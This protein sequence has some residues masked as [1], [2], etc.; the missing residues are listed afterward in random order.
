MRFQFTLLSL[1]ASIAGLAFAAPAPIV[2]APALNRRGST[3]KTVTTATN[4]NLSGASGAVILP[5]PI[6]SNSSTLNPPPTGVNSTTNSTI[7]LLVPGGS[8]ST[9]FTGRPHFSPASGGIVIPHHNSTGN[10]TIGK[11][12]TTSNAHQLASN[13]SSSSNSTS[14]AGDKKKTGKGDEKKKEAEKKKAEKKEEERK[15]AAAAAASASNST[16]QPT[17]DANSTALPSGAAGD[18]DLT[19][20]GAHLT[21]LPTVTADTVRRFARRALFDRYA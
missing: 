11:I 2:A 17:D 20:L 8:N 5:E 3:I 10:G 14:G 18:G 1:V 12:G 6:I 9:N 19:I 15:K 16:A 13:S 4:P 21:K 7:P